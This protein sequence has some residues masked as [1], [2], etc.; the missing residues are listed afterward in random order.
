METQ[1]VK[2][3]VE[4]LEEISESYSGKT[5]DNIISQLKSK[6]NYYESSRKN[7]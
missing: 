3:W 2:T 5:I 4:T 1:K 7:S 6:L